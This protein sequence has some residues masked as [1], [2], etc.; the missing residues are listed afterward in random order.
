MNADKRLSCSFLPSHP[1]LSA[2]IRGLNSSHLQWEPRTKNH[3]SHRPKTGISPPRR[4]HP[5]RIPRTLGDRPIPA[6]HRSAYPTQPRHRG[7]P[8]TP[9][10]RPP[11]TGLRLSRHFGTSAEFRI[12]LQNEY[13]LRKARTESG[14][15]IR[16]VG[17]DAGSLFPRQRLDLWRAEN[18]L[19]PHGEIRIGFRR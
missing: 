11:D 14:A 1:C 3:E 16:F 6:R 5:L 7:H 12:G 4:D 17:F 8:Q 19:N 10:H 13:D 15:A 9:L 18:I 2:L